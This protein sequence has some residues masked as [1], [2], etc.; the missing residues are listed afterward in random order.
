M[1][2]KLFVLLGLAV[3]LI[4][5]TPS[6]AQV[7]AKTEVSTIVLDTDGDGI[8]DMQD[9][10]PNDVGPKNHNTKTNGCTAHALAR[11]WIVTFITKVSPPGRKT[12]FTHAQETREEALVRYGEIADNLLAAVYD[13]DIKPLFSGSL[14]R[15]RTI[16]LMLGVMFWETGFRRD[17]DLGLGK[18]ARGDNGRSWCL[19]QIN[20]GSGK[21]A[22]GY[23]GEDLV[24]NRRIC[25]QEGL[26]VIRGSFS[27]CRQLP[28]EHR[29]SAY[30]SGSCDKGRDKS[31]QRVQTGMQWFTNSRALRLF[32]D[33]DLAPQPP[34][35]PEDAHPNPN[36]D[37]VSFLSPI[38]K[39]RTQ[40][41][42]TR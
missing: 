18:H 31:R 6:R 3:I 37:R 19:M 38:S 32:S 36:S 23:T 30:A 29:L 39:E 34:A 16:S 15:A 28:L 8:T 20:L 25:F 24:K 13:P 27:A 12:Y 2:L 5:T 14:G 41:D 10:C 7:S 21:T 42:P 1:R 26:R 4:F 33:I 40:D 9:A 17:V 22:L 35:P 11:Q